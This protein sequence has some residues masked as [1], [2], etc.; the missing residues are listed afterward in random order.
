MELS[1]ISEKFI[2]HSQYGRCRIQNCEEKESHCGHG[3]GC[4][5]VEDVTRPI[6]SIMENL[7]CGMNKMCKRIPVT[8]CGTKYRTITECCNALGIRINT[9]YKKIRIDNMP[10]EQAI[11]ASIPDI[12]EVDG[13]IYKTLKAI[14]E[15]YNLPYQAFRSR[16]K[17]GWTVHDAVYAPIGTSRFNLKR[18]KLG[19][20]LYTAKELQQITG[21][22]ISSVYHKFGEY[23][24]TSPNKHHMPKCMRARGKL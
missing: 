6:A 10:L 1:T 9:V 12:Y 13:K 14:A 15:D 21:L 19:D 20:K 5:S 23:S 16:I 18:F 24:T 7:L 17:L 11:L 3:Q 4:F 22:N 8:V 2:N